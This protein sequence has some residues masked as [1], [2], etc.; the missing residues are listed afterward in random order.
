M[1][2]QLRPPDFFLIGAP[3]AG[4][5]ALH[6]ALAQ[7][8]DLLLSRTKEPKYY[9]CGDAPPPAYRGPGD[10]HSNQE[11]VWR[12]RDYLSLFAGGPPA[13]LRGE[14]TPF[15][16]YRRDALRRIVE[17]VPQAR[18]VAVLRDPVDRA[19]SNW[20]HLWMD[21]LE[22]QPDVVEAVRLEADRIDRGWAPFWHYRGLGMY[23]RQVA[24]LL[25]LVERDR[26]LLLRYRDLVDE[27]VRTLDRVFRFLGVP[28]VET[29]TVPT[30]NSRVYVQ[31]G[32]RVRLLSPVV[33]GGAALG[34]F[35]P[36][37]VWRRA[38]RPLVARL[39]RGGDVARPR[40]TPDQRA[41]LLEPHL[42]D[43][44]LLEQVTGESY[45]DWRG[46]RDGDSF[47]SRRGGVRVS[48][49]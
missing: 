42:A 13:A 43:I 15:Y 39:H 5:S 46:H 16:L 36:P 40:L 33:R 2:D 37:E 10:A 28:S 32:L 3:K 29:V 18:M 23:G 24:D 35:L 21:G 47:H 30:D 45:A 48:A 49:R 4:T 26:L 11:W 44:E 22:P 7:H 27:P 25:Q 17:D 14:S 19:Y 34:Q 41:A 9:L 6:A 1:S 8:P 38:S 31:D 20:M 12:R